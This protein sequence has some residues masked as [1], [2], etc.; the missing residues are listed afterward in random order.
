MASKPKVRAFLICDGAFR[1]PSTGKVSLTGTFDNIASKKFPAVHGN[2]A[3]YF[4]VTDLNGDY[5]FAVVVVAP[6]LVTEVARLSFPKRTYTD[7]LQPID[8]PMNLPKLVLPQAGRYTIRLLYNGLIADEFSLNVR[9][10]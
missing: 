1:D 6:D 10:A 3:V 4:K 2:F 9:Q 5:E 8:I 7:P